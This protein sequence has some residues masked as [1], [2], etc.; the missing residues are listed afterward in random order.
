MS[1]VDTWFNVIC[2]TIVQRCA[3]TSSANKQDLRILAYSVKVFNSLCSA[4]QLL[5]MPATY[6][7]TIVWTLLVRGT[8][9][10]SCMWTYRISTDRVQSF[11]RRWV[12]ERGSCKQREEVVYQRVNL[13]NR[14]RI[15]LKFTL[16]NLEGR[17][18]QACCEPSAWC[19]CEKFVSHRFMCSNFSRKLDEFQSVKA[20]IS[21]GLIGQVLTNQTE[22]SWRNEVTC[23]WMKHTTKE[24]HTM[25]RIT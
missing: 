24:A 9:K 17:K 1:W 20:K 11:F 7:S 12:L 4:A 2:S 6:G 13:I 15:F 18:D 8:Q 5:Y 3:V 19:E 21:F 25:N 23:R 22:F 10:I 16:E 14:K